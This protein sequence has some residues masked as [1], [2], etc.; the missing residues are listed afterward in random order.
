MT[1]FKVIKSFRRF[2]EGSREDP[3]FLFCYLV[4]LIV[5]GFFMYKF[6]KGELR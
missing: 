5:S 3:T 1:G 2:R 4:I 6:V